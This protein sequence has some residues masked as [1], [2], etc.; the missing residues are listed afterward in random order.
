MREGTCISV[1]V[2]IYNTEKYLDA[3]ITSIVNQTYS[4]L[5]IILV[6]DGSPD[7]CG[8][9]CDTWVKK[10]NRI[11]VIHQENAGV[12]AARN[13]GLQIATG[14]LIS[15]VDSDDVLPLNAYEQLLSS[16]NEKDLTMGGM[17]LMEEDGTSIPCEQI[18]PPDAYPIEDFIKELFREKQFCY[19][20][21]LWDKLL[22]RA[23][24]Q[25]NNIRFDPAI[26]LN[27]DRLFLLEY[28]L[29]SSSMSFC[30]AVIYY[31]RQRGAGVITST[32]RNRTVT[33]S[34]MTV[35]DSFHKMASIAKQYSEELYYIVARKAFESSL[36]LRSRVAPED[37]RKN[38]QILHFMQEYAH[39]CMRTPDISMNE[40]LKIVGHCILKK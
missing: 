38:K 34:E 10:D 37:K 29:H 22:K 15:F 21:Y 26:K 14:E 18:I 13:A 9:I 39:I 31:Y 20:G 19:L 17:A 1:I 30:N 36:D 40:R 24:I 7:K 5:Q 4:A 12:S 28:L 11:Q 33:D 8:I 2:P 6:D 25:D 32:R 27:E 16:W 3:C 35:I 23:I